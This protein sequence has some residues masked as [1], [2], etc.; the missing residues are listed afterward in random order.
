M[1]TGIVE[2]AGRV[3]GVR[4]GKKSTE[5]VVRARKVAR[6]LRVGSSLAVN[7]ACLT[8]V[9]NR[10]GLLRFDV[11][12]ETLRRT[13]LAFVRAGDRVNFE[14]PLRAN[15]RLDGHFV[16]GHVDARGTVRR[17]ARNGTDYVLD[18][19]APASVM[20]YILEKG[21]VAV[22]G[23]SLTVARAGRGWFRVW[24]IPHTRSVTNLRT[25]RAGDFV[26]LE[27]DVLGKYVEKLLT[28]GV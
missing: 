20:K 5:F 25:R 24:I 23:I 11:L 1:F 26:N 27:A 15:A 12:E 13:N 16:L 6:S 2:E 4:R 21:S 10:K 22:D 17:F 18:V 7:G 28:R 3:E 8:V 19:A 9:S 14:R